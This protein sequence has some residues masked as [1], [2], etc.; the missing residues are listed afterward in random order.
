MKVREIYDAI[1]AFAPYAAQMPWD[2]SGLAVGSMDDE[3]DR[4]LVTIDCSPASL[5]AARRNGCGL[6][7]THHPVL[8]HAAKSVLSDSFVYRAVRQGVAVLSAHTNYDMAPGGVNDVLAA[9]LGLTDPA[10]VEA[11]GLPMMRIGSTQTLMRADAFA[12]FVADRLGDPVKYTAFPGEIRRVAVCGG[13]GGDYIAEAA[14]AGADAF[15]TGEVKH[16][17]FYEAERQGLCLI[18]AGHFAT[19]EPAVRALR[20]RLQQQFPA[21]RFI[22][23]CNPPCRALTPKEPLWD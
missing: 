15:V 8:F 19:E 12:Q 14:A 10:V 18:E 7:V 3:F 17:M 21:A 22:H 9:Q 2:N 5:E 1:D 6:I 4:A 11:E 16:H 23:F 20:D 13:A